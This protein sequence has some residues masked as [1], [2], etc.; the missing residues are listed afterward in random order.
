MSGTARL[1]PRAAASAVA[2]IVFLVAGP[3]PGATAAKKFQVVVFGDSFGSGEGAPAVNGDYGSDGGSLRNQGVLGI[4]NEGSRP[5]PN[6]PADWAG[7]DAD[8]A[9]TGDTPA[10]A[11]R[12]HRSPRATAPR[13][14]RLL[15]AEF[16][17]IDFSFRSFACSGARI[18][19][20]VLGTYEGAQ[21][22]DQQNRVPSQLSQANSYLND[23]PGGI[24]KRIDALVMNIGGNN[25]GFANVMQRCLNLPPFAFNPC[26]PPD[27]SDN[28]EGN[29]DTL[30]VI[31]TGE[32]SGEP[33]NQIG[34]DNLPGL[35]AE[36]NRKITRAPGTTG[37]LLAVKPKEIYLTT[38][39]NPVAGQKGAGCSLTGD[40]DYEKNLRT[41][42]H[43]WLRDTVFP[44]LVNAMVDAAGANDWELVEL[45]PAAPSNG[46]CVGTNRFFNRNRDAL[47][48]QG[49]TVASVAGIAVSHGIGHPN[50]DGYQAIAPVL[51]ARLRPQVIQ[52]FTPGQ[53]PAGAAQ[54]AP[55]T[56]LANR[57]QLRL[58]DPPEDYRTR[59]GGSTQFGDTAVGALGMGIG[60]VDV[61]VPTNQD[62]MALL[63]RR[64]GP[65]SPSVTPPAGCSAER[66]VFGVLTG[67][68][69][70]PTGV[71]AAPSLLN[72]VRVQWTK[73][74]PPERTLRRFL[75]TA[76][77]S[78]R[79]DSLL[80]VL[81]VTHNFTIDPSLRSTVLPLEQGDW[82]VSVRE[83]TDRG[84]GSAS[85]VVAV[86]SNGVIEFDASDLQQDPVL[87]QNQISSPV[88]LFSTPAGRRAR[89]GR[90]FP[91]QVSWGVW[92]RWRELRE[93]RLRLV[94]E[95]DEL[96]TITVRLDTGRVIVDGPDTRARRG[97]LGRRGTLGAGSFALRT[98]D[99]RIVGSS[100]RRGRLVAIDLPLTLS[101][102]L[103]RQRVDV[104]VAASLRNGRRQDFGPA[105]SFE[106]R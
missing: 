11:R 18:D 43:N 12:C 2:A 91:L 40:Y 88:G 24:D 64:C 104:D 19:E 98:R 26:S 75:V 63:A 47:R 96:G 82:R 29:N 76:D 25:L 83:C 41:D 50:S 7:S 57:V 21:P 89:A 106:V 28:G 60:T 84:C 36:L 95:R 87:N 58:P 3:V 94:G 4:I 93:M 62:T 51:A 39:P 42:E 86:R 8:E 71:T 72:G 56:T 65:L 85:A 16:P 79:T 103:R 53:P 78:V 23:L 44:T 17:D 69:G 52:G 73:G 49:A 80:G 27:A 38:P 70:V 1:A 35:Y 97:R 34:L 48:R 31:Q 15:A 66:P 37:T 67:T 46:I 32:G 20:G 105:G 90:R 81:N 10:A 55:V 92:R 30:N 101:R 6:P 100:G 77:S 54:P 13:A 14:V 61:P 5:L 59:P 74:S 45:G 33:V 102:R 68:P 99:A 9:F 22:I